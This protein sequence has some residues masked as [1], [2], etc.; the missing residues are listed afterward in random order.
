MEEFT[1][2]P[3]SF[4][5]LPK[6]ESVPLQPLNRDY[7]NVVYIGNTVF[8]ILLSIGTLIFLWVKEES[9]PLILPTVGATVIL[10]ALLFWLSTISFRKKGYALREKD[11]LFQKGILSRT[12]TVIPF[13]RIQH[14]ALH[15]GFF[16]RMYQ[17]S[18]LQIYTAGG[19]SSDLHIPGLPKEQAEQMKTFLLQKITPI[20]ETS[21]PDSLLA[22]EILEKQVIESPAQEVETKSL[23]EKDGI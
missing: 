17:L 2:N 6:F 7:L 19:S 3:V 18:E 10:I 23:N 9:Q 16:S 15:E 8:A 4:E 1:N 22:E 11:I 21:T 5:T 12:T 13:S 14:V 20:V